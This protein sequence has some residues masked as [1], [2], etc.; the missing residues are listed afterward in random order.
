[1]KS[2]RTQ[3]DTDAHA[4]TTINRR[5]GSKLSELGLRLDPEAAIPEVTLFLP[6]NAK[7]PRIGIVAAARPNFMKVAPIVRALEGRINTELVHTGQHYDKHMSGSFFEELRL[8]APDVNLGIGSGT[9]A[10]QTAG[11]MIAF[12]HY[13]RDRNID[14]VVVVGDV[15]STL[16]CAL[17]AV[18]L[19]VPV[20]HVEAGLR[21]G[22]WSMPE[23]VN[24][25]V[26]DRVSRWLFTTSADADVNLSAEGIPS[27]WIHLVGNVMIDTLL[28]NLDRA[29]ERGQELRKRLGL[30]S[31]YALM[32]LHRPSNVDAARDLQSL[33]SAVAEEAHDLP[34]I[35]PLHPRTA[36][37][38]AEFGI[39]LPS[40]IQPVE[41]LSYLDFVGLVDTAGI[42]LTDSGGV[43]EET[44][45]LGVPC[46]TLRTSTERP[47]TCKFG[48]NRLAGTEPH[49]VR[50]A[51]TEAMEAPRLPARIPLWDGKAGE[52]IA[53]ILLHDLGLE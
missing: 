40:P 10:E 3:D 13:L 17:T 25:L 44:T 52:R 4:K 36:A 53:E 42:V 23:E 37:R 18:K 8:P 26:T 33:L 27:D 2:R 1:M 51:F 48:T 20:A 21:S 39:D 46:V 11:V 16:A 32:T 28:K 22:D 41:P 9:H 6:R 14:V 30:D 45:V 15:N 35:F 43:Q 19:W 24:R 34:V 12:E 38:L 47:V 7:Q 50:R 49:A 31:D 5:A 29:R